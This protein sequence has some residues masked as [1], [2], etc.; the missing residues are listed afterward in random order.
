MNHQSL[1]STITDLR[2][3]AQT[4]TPKENDSKFKNIDRTHKIF[5]KLYPNPLIYK[6]SSLINNYNPSN[7]SLI[8]K[9]LCIIIAIAK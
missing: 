4:T 7:L 2:M 6:N 3:S 5:M 1:Q 9:H 8:Y